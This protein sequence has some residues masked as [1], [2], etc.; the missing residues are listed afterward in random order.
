MSAKLAQAVAGILALTVLVAHGARAQDVAPAAP[1]FSE[2]QLDQMLAPIAL[3]PDPLLGQILMAATYPLE[4]VEADRWLQAPGNAGLQ[5]EQLAAALQLQP[6]DASVKSLAP[7]PQV[8]HMMDNN[9]DWTEEV[10]DAFLAQQAAVMDSVQRLRSRAQAS[11]ALVSTP[12]Q[13][14]SEQ[15]G[16]IVIEPANP[17]VIYIPEY[18]PVLDYGVWPWPEYPPSWLYPWPGFAI[19][20]AIG[21]PIISPLWGWCHWDWRHHRL[22]IDPGRFNAVNRRDP[23]VTATDW[24]H[25][26]V[27]RHGVPYRDAATRERFLGE[28]AVSP[29]TSRTLR[30]YDVPAASSGVRAQPQVARAPSSAVRAPASEVHAQSRFTRA[31]TPAV[32]APSAVVHAPPPAFE[33][34]GSGAAVRSEAARGAASRK[35]PP[36]SGGGSGRQGAGGSGNV[37]HP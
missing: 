19:G 15:D 23:P 16:I 36:G 1:V 6:W 11:G 21:I 26:V 27:H 18:N 30:G 31:P 4:V 34:F 35:I 29:E 20:F 14:V 8:L 17:E 24:R 5:G 13:A 3:Y 28:A 32:R 22:G 9:L 25:N 33:S 37:R 10:G 2:Q 7:F 12:Q